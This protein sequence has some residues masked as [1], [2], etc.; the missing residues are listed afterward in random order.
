MRWDVQ[1]EAGAGGARNMA[2]DEYALRRAADAG[3][4]SL[5]LYRWDRLTLSV[6]RAQQVQ[7][8]I[9]VAECARLR[10]P[11][12]RRPTG[13]RAVLHGTDL[14]Y[15]LAAPLGWGPFQGGILEVYREI[16]RAFVRFFTELGL[17]PHVQGFSLRER[18]QAASSV[19]FATP[20]AYE[21]LLGGRKILGS[22]QRLVPRAFLQHGS[23]P[24]QPQQALLERIFLGSAAREIGEQMTDLETAAGAPV[25]GASE[26]AQRIVAAFQAEFGIEAEPMA[27]N[28]QDEAAVLALEAN[29]PDLATLAPGAAEGPGPGRGE[30]P[31]VPALATQGSGCPA[32]RARS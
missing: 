24:L 21:I 4:P 1:I 5:R 6:G 3:R 2:R 28:A 30:A 20:S 7:R 11:I 31:R 15:A 25:W 13:G 26:L 18:G 14:T 16:S 32:G 23:L 9:D 22:A 10:V 29:Y 27:W 19:C 12:V 8:Q 17:H